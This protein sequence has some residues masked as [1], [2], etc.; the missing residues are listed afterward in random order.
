MSIDASRVEEIYAG[1]L[2][3]DL[4]SDDPNYV[5]VQGI[6]HQTAFDMRKLLTHYDEVLDMLSW[7]PAPYRPV[8][9]VEG[10]GGGWSFLNACDD[11]EGNQWTGLHRTMDQLFQ[12]GIGL[13]LA[14]YLMDREMWSAFPGG[15]PYAAVT[16]PGDVA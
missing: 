11:R 13:G 8:G 6:L 1:S 3:E 16:L 7:L 10:G 15:M 4:S 9:S 5:V 14:A 2:A 12:L